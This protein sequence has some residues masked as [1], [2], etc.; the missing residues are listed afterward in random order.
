MLASLAGRLRDWRGSLSG[1][2][3]VIAAVA[4]EGAHRAGGE[5]ARAEARVDEHRMAIAAGRAAMERQAGWNGRAGMTA[6]NSSS[7]RP[8]SQSR[9]RRGG[10]IPSDMGIDETR[11]PDATVKA[12]GRQRG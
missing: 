6:A 11:L 5:V 4:Q 12:P 10:A 7:A 2:A 9:S 3:D 1:A 8:S